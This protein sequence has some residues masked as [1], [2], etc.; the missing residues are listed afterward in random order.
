VAF[1]AG[2]KRGV[3]EGKE[4]KLQPLAVVISNSCATG[5]TICRIFY[6]AG[7][8]HRRGDPRHLSIGRNGKLLDMWRESLIVISTSCNGVGCAVGIGRAEC[9]SMP[10]AW[11]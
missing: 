10:R 3:K 8:R 4:E 11:V 9:T 5:R 6:V 1:P 2:S 7:A